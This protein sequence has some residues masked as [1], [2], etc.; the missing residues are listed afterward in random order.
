MRRYRK[1]L[2]ARV[3]NPVLTHTEDPKPRSAEVSDRS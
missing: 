2:L 1:H 3:L